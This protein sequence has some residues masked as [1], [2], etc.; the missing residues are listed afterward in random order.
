MVICLI[1]WCKQFIVKVFDCQSIHLSVF[2]WDNE[3][4]V[5]RG[6]EHV[7]LSTENEEYKMLHFYFKY[8][9]N[10]KYAK[11]FKIRH[12]EVIYNCL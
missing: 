5:A 4:T 1:I 9:W 2:L 12:G 6:E 10:Q 3:D 7:F 11:V 8:F